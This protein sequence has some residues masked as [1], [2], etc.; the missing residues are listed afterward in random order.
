MDKIFKLLFFASFCLTPV[1]ALTQTTPPQPPQEAIAACSGGGVG[2]TCSF[3]TPR[4]TESG[5]CEQNP[6]GSLVCKPGEAPSA[7]TPA[8]TAPAPTTPT[9]ALP[10]TN[11]TVTTPQPKADEPT[12]ATDTAMTDMV[13]ATREPTFFERLFNF[14]FGW[15]FRKDTETESIP[16][17]DA[18][19]PAVETTQNEPAKNDATTTNAEDVIPAE[20]GIQEETNPTPTTQAGRSDL[21]TKNSVSTIWTIPDT[22]QTKCYDNSREITCPTSASKEF[23]G[24]DA[25]YAGV[26]MNYTNNGDGTV[27]DNV[28]GLMWLKDAGDKVAYYTGINGADSY[29]YAGYSDWRVPTIK[30][31]YSLIDFS[32]QDV[33]PMAKNANTPFINTNYFNFEYGDTS[34]GDRVIDSQWITSNIYVAK[35]M[36]NQECFFGVNFAD[37]R[38]KCYPTA[39]N[40]HNNGYFMRLVRGNTGYGENNFT[41]GGNGTVTDTS[42]GLTWQQSD[43]RK[44]MDW[45]DALNY[46]EDLSLGGYTDWRLPNA[47]ELE[48]IVDY[49]RSP[50]TT[51]SPAIDP[52]FTT[53]SITNEAGQKDWPYF[54][55]GTT[56]ANAQG[57]SEGVYVPFGRAIG[58]MNG[59]IMDVHGAGA[60]R[61]DPK[62]GDIDDYPQY[63]GPQGDARRLHNFVRCVR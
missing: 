50:V 31:L 48:Y 59:Q 56:H 51:N 19:A 30:E 11:E 45:S 27:T 16:E 3:T 42:S 62:S 54:W 7:T 2:Q 46:C 1:T 22:G 10:E 36:N 6:E 58:Q 60:Q 33:D 21:P 8:A 26:P 49:S 5:V 52:I 23:Y 55:T 18:P 28:T 12:L 41:A 4:G 14:F 32:G 20:A 44:G 35:V 57:G 39:D 47:H 37:G 29:T 24:Q 43:S 61:S 17:A 63:F 53:S 15:L 25:S 40:G 34:T 38:I 9:K 13:T